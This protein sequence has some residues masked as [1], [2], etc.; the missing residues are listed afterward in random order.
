MVAWGLGALHA[1]GVATVGILRG[2]GCSG[3]GLVG[4]L[5]G[6][7]AGAALTEQVPALIQRD[8]D[9]VE[10]L[11][12]RGVQRAGGVVAFEVVF[13]V[14]ELTDGRQQLGVVDGGSSWSRVQCWARRVCRRL[15]RAASAD[16]ARS[17]MIAAPSP[18]H[19][20]GHLGLPVATGA[21]SS[22]VPLDAACG[23]SS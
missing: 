2:A 4:V 7:S 23:Q 14:D 13:F 19:C 21:A 6:V 5:A 12:A 3:F 1:C 22:P 8:R 16:V 10:A 11:L 18:P 9:V 15:D 20:A 17:R